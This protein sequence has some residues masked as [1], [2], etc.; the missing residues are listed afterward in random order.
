V[1]PLVRLVVLASQCATRDCWTKAQF[2]ADLLR[3]GSLEAGYAG[4]F[5]CSMA[6]RCVWNNKL[7]TQLLLRD[8]ASNIKMAV[9][10]TELR[11]R[12]AQVFTSSVSIDIWRHLI[13]Q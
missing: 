8:W 4:T 3:N 11:S 6:D 5:E 10:G 2:Y 7:M 1:L 12:L 13:I 9:I